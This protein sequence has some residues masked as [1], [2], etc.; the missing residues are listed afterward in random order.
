MGALFQFPSP[1]RF[2]MKSAGLFE[3]VGRH[4]PTMM[5]GGAF[6]VEATKL[7]YPPKGKVERRTARRAIEVLEGMAEPT[8]KPI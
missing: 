2:W 7:V 6:M 1:Q 4:M 5:A 8:A 3:K